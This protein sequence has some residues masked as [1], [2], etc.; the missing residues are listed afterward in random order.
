MFSGSD[1]TGT[2]IFGGTG[3]IHNL[4]VL[5]IYQLLKLANLWYLVSIPEE[6]EDNYISLTDIAKSKEADS[7][8]EPFCQ[9]AR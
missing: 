7:C 3:N 2:H 1:Y 9:N 8:G 4:C 6:E 5:E